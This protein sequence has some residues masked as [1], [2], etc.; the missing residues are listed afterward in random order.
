MTRRLFVPLLALAAAHA[1]TLEQ[2]IQSRLN[3]LRDETGYP[4][5]TVGVVLA[6]GQRIM[7]A[8]GLKPSDRMLAGSTGKTFA[9]AVV[10]Q[11]VS[12]PLGGIV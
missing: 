8:S 7:A 6:D 12:F 10:L 2:Q 3:E 4:G 5:I 11:A 9:A 1:A